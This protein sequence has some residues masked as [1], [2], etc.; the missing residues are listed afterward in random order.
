[1]AIFHVKVAIINVNHK[2]V[3]SPFERQDE[4]QNTARESRI[5]SLFLKS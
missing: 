1:M 2:A 5:T 3:V 4:V